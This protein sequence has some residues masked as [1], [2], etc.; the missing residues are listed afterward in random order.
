MANWRCPHCRTPQPEAARCWV[1]RRSS[2]SCGTCAHFRR[3]IAGS[4]G[5]TCGLDRRRSVLRGD[6]LRGCWR[7]IPVA[8]GRSGNGVALPIIDPAGPP[9]PAPGTLWS[10]PEI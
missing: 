10:E 1:C 7:P 2:T 5:G 6:E 8:V 4:F 3:A 9:F